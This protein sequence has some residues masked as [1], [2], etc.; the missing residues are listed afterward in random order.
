MFK[1]TIDP[2][3]FPDGKGVL[4]AAV[5]DLMRQAAREVERGATAGTLRDQGGQVVGRYIFEPERA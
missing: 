3:K 2:T 5:S 4:E 1:L